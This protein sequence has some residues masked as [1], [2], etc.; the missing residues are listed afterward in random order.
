[1]AKNISVLVSAAGWIGGFIDKL[2][3][4]LRE[5]GIS[6]EEV[7]ALVT[8]RGEQLFAKIADAVAELAKQAKNFFRL[9][10]I[11]GPLAPLIEQGKYGSVNSNIADKNFPLPDELKKL[12]KAD[13]Q[14]QLVHYGKQMGSEEVL[15]DLDQ[16]GLRA[17]NIWELLMFGIKN[18][19]LQ[20]QFPIVA[21]GPVWRGRAGGRDVACL[22]SDGGGRGLYLFWFGLNW[23][24]H[25]RFLAVSK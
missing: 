6:D 1:M 25:Y 18:S 5:R 7:H 20:R 2:V 12:G 16:K 24:G 14:A 15:K 22:W 19:E 4:A 21:L 13:V 9:P 3:K 8:E 23:G 17:A 10:V 11:Y